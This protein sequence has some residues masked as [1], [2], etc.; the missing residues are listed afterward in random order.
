MTNFTISKIATDSTTRCLHYTEMQSTVL[1]FC[2]KWKH[3]V[4]AVILK[5]FSFINIFH[6]GWIVVSFKAI[7]VSHKH[8]YDSPDY[9]VL[10]QT[11]PTTTF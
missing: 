2:L 3:A 5:E 8:R 11:L 1:V 7:S 6:L 4:C 9:H 10:S